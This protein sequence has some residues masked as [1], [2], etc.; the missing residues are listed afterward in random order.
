MEY[1]VSTKKTQT[2]KSCMRLSERKPSEKNISIW[3]SMCDIHRKSK[4]WEQERGQSLPK[5]ERAWV[6][7]HRAQKIK[8]LLRLPVWH[9]DSGCMVSHISNPMVRNKREGW[10]SFC[11]GCWD[12]GRC[13]HL[14]LSHLGNSLLPLSSARSLNFLYKL[15]WDDDSYAQW[16][17]SVISAL[18]TGMVGMQTQRQPCLQTSSKPA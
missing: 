6:W 14:G 4:L 3:F 17:T 8:E 15:I 16:L 1:L 9:Y 11:R 5:A 10:W 12:T 18:R 13:A 2:F 7:T